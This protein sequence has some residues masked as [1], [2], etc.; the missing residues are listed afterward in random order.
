MS[1]LPPDYNEEDTSFT[2]EQIDLIT[3]G[4]EAGLVFS[5]IDDNSVPVFIGKKGQFTMF[6][7]LRQKYNI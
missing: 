2:T 4:E 3:T 6:E 1:N 7:L 5:E